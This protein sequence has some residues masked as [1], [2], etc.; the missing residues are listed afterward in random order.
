MHEN[1]RPT[2]QEQEEA[3]DPERLEDEEDMRYPSPGNADTDED[4]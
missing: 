1:P 3:Q 4:D 2:E